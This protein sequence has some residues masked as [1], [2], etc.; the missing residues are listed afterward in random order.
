LTSNQ[1]PGR[2]PDQS[3]KKACPNPGGNTWQALLHQK[4]EGEVGESCCPRGTAGRRR[5][6]YSENLVAK[7]VLSGVSYLSGRGGKAR[8][9]GR[10]ILFRKRRGD[11]RGKT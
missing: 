2:K 6:I 10:G 4:G 1:A 3:R 5:S 7:A 8:E 9:K 11:A